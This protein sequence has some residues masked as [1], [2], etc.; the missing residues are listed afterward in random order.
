MRSETYGGLARA[1]LMILDTGKAVNI[2]ATSRS[3][4][5]YWQMISMPDAWM[6]SVVVVGDVGF[7]LTAS[8]FSKRLRYQ[9]N[10]CKVG[11]SSGESDSAR[12][13]EA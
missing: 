1:A 11:I 3:C 5:M 13:V 2:L 9:F 8:N 4:S 10:I 6:A 7:S 12:M